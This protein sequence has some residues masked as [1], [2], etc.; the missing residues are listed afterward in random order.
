MFTL[1]LPIFC[2]VFIDVVVVVFSV[3]V[4]RVPL[5]GS[6]WSLYAI[7]GG[8]GGRRE[9]KGEV[10]FRNLSHGH[11]WQSRASVCHS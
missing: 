1:I 5:L 8:E 11:V 9:A 3:V 10:L 7:G 2:L 6:S 4:S